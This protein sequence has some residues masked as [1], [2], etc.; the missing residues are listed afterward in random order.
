M[1]FADKLIDLRKRSGWSQEELADRLG[2]SRQSV[3]K[4][5]SAQSVP[6]MNRILKLSELFGVS[7][8]Y[9][10]KDELG[11]ESMGRELLPTPDT[12]PPLRQVDLE[13]AAAF[14]E[15][16]GMAARRVALG[17]MLC[18]LSPILLIV[19]CGARDAGR[20]ALTEA[21]AAGIGLVGIFVLV[22]AAVALFI[23]T[24][25]QGHRFEYLEKLPFETAYGVDGMVKD[26]REKYRRSFGTMLTVGIVL[27]VVSV[28]P[29]FIA[30]ILFG[31]GNTDA[32]AFPH[33]VSI[34]IL[35]ALV[36]VGVYLII[37]SSMI[38]GACKILLQ[39]GEYSPVVKRAN[40]ANQTLTTVY[41]SAVTAGYLAVSFITN[42][43][44]RTWIVWPVAGV[45][46][47]LVLAVAGAIR[48]RKRP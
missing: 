33:I 47:G 46:F 6:D 22:G 4:W 48:S 32:E 30:L 3:S 21:Q 25:L 41:W 28:I 19:L 1:I 18:I 20:V 12:E 45:L 27:C 11:P 13:E 10:L 37:R 43:W 38:W 5:E 24:G 44:D 15:Y 23:T 2:V 8:D 7:T 9:L 26:R 42:R 39:E 31:E 17:V 29:I 36:A 14:L 40:S 35:L 16:R 34:G